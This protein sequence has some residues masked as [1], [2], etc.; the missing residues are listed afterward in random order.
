MLTVEMVNCVS[1][2]H[3]CIYIN[4]NKY[5]DKYIVV[6]VILQCLLTI[7]TLLIVC[8]ADNGDA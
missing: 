8:P 4:D 7:N 6:N 1:F 5:I 2:M 3:I